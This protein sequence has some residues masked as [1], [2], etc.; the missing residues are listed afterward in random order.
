MYTEL[1][2][3]RCVRKRAIRENI[4]G[5]FID[6]VLVTFLTY[7]SNAYRITISSAL[8]HCTAISHALRL[9]IIPALVSANMVRRDNGLLFA[10]GMLM[11]LN[12]KR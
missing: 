7:T 6:N 9:A 12:C 5:S 3:R 1:D 2:T 4:D 8:P 10:I 11:G